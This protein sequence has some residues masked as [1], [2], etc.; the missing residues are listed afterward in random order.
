[1][2]YEMSLAARAM[3]KAAFADRYPI[4]YE[5][6]S[7]KPPADGSMYLKFDYIEA[8]TLRLSLSRKCTSYIGLVQVGITF[9]PGRGVDAARQLAVEVAETAEDG[10]M[11]KDDIY[12]YE[13]GIVHPVQK[14][15][16]GWLYP[17]RFYVRVDN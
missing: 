11:L 15:E 12:I 1:M 13:G 10:R 6:D 3:V 2:H 5:N 17:V 16:T 7:A 8:D 9:P 4:I 14:S